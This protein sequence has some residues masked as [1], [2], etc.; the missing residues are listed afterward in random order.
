[1]AEP[2][3]EQKYVLADDRPWALL[4]PELFAALKAQ[5]CG[6][7]YRGQAVQ[8]DTY[9]DTPDDAVLRADSALRVRQ[10][11]QGCRLTWKTP[12]PA[13]GAA[14]ARNEEEVCLASPQD[15][16]ALLDTYRAQLPGAGA[17]PL[18]PVLVVENLR[19]TYA[20]TCGGETY[21][22]ALDTVRYRTMGGQRDYRERQLELERK[23]GAGAALPRLAAALETA[24]PWLVPADGSKYRRARKFLAGV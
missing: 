23:T 19:K 9:Y 18:A 3:L 13:Q 7:E 20:V 24:C 1:M 8:T 14:F 17:L 12:A 11:E 16:D 22:L 5:G 4:E 10:T 6:A 2:E 15:R 21:E